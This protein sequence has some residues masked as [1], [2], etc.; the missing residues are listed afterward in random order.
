MLKDIRLIISN[1]IENFLNS[2]E[3]ETT[4]LYTIRITQ[5]D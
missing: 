5:Q 2:E 3:K 1:N 4:K